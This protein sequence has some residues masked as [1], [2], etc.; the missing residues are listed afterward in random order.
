MISFEND[1]LEGA[2][3]KVLQRLLDTNLIQASGY[4][5]DQFSKKAAEQ[6]KATIKCPE[7]TVRFLVGGTQT[8]Q[9]VINSVLESYEGVISA[10]TGHVAVHEGGAIEFSGH[11]VL[12]I[13]SHEGKITPKKVNAYLDTFYS[14]FKR[15]HMVFPGMVYIS[16]PTEYG[17]LYSKE[18]LKNL[19]A[20]CKEHKVPLFMDGARLGYGLM[21][22]QSDLTIEDIAKYCDIFYIGGTK[23]GALC[24][25][26][27]VFTNNNEP[28]HFT[29]RIKQHGALLA[30]GRLVGVQFLELFTNNLYFDISRHAINMANKMKKGFIEKGYQVYFDSPTNQQF[31]VLSEDKIKELQQKVKFAVWE[32]Y[33]DNHRVVRFATS[34]ATT[35]E[36]VD[37]LLELI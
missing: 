3:E 8:N 2:H 16:H 31:F 32:K 10:D 12:A 1:Y 26:A 14:D 25:E 9:V 21:S 24:G 22:D 35:E 36:N 18:E 20:V 30:K 6:I 28:K 23:I 34:W 27:I 33:D 7:A 4:G 15:E 11:K 37:K 17:T 13:P 19:A 29:T 5:D